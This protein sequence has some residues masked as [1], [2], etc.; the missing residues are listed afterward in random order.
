[1]RWTHWKI[2]NSVERQ[3]Q[4]KNKKKSAPFRT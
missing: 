3:W 2:L 4:K 1:M